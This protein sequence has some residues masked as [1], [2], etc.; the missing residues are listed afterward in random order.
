MENLFNTGKE[1]IYDGDKKLTVR[2]LSVM[3]VFK[4][5]RLLGK[6]GTGAF[7]QLSSQF[8]MTRAHAENAELSEDQKKAIE[9]QQKAQAQEL[10]FTLF[11]TMADYENEFIDF[12][13]GLTNL[14]V[15]EFKMLPPDVALDVI[16]TLAEGEDLK[17][18][19][20]KARALSVKFIP[21]AAAPAQA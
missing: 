18:F 12:L 8:N 4:F 20:E 5:A 2:R 10:G 3:D 6:V 11:A 19:F 17:R 16:V 14:K 13:G 9:E 21:Q 15:D 7:A 1:I